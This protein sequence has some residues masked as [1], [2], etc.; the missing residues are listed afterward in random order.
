MHLFDL[1]YSENISERLGDINDEIDG[2]SKLHYQ[3]CLVIH[4]LGKITCNGNG[5]LS[6]KIC[7]KD[8]RFAFLAL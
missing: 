6:Q 5:S 4:H 2:R 3:H 8:S 7:S 1:F